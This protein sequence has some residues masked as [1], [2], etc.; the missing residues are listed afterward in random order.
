MHKVLLDENLPVEIK[1]RLQGVCEIY[2]VADKHWNSLETGDLINAMQNDKFDFF[3]YF[4][5]K[6]AIPT[7]HCKIFYRIY[8]FK[9]SR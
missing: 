4:R 6:P 2:T 8:N 7:K 3:D 1:Y 5:Q 9:R